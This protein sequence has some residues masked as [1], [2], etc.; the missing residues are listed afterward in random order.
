[1]GLTLILYASFGTGHERAAMAIQEAVKEYYPHEHV[2]M[3][4]VLSFSNKP[5][6]KIYSSVYF[7]II[8]KV[9][10][11]WGYLFDMSD[12]EFSRKEQKIHSLFNNISV[13]QLKKYLLKKKPDRV[14]CTHFLPLER[15]SALKQKGLMRSQLYCAITDYCVHALWI[16]KNVDAYFVGSNEAKR[17]L[18][19][20]G[21]N[22]DTIHV[23]GIPISLEFSKLTNVEKL[24]KRMKITHDLPVV[25]CMSGGFGLGPMEQILDSFAFH[26]VK[27]QIIIS[28][29]RNRVMADSIAKNRS[30]WPFPIFLLPYVTN[31][32]E[33]F[34]LADVVV[35]KPGGLSTTE[36]MAKEKPLIIINPIPGQE[37]RNSDFLLENGI[38]AKAQCPRDVAYKTMEILYNPSI[39]SRMKR[40]AKK[41]GRPNAAKDIA[42]IIYKHNAG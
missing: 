4:D 39:Y 32:H 31:L 41:F 11:L 17:E 42:D 27:A 37:E 7:S 23:K 13:Y 26:N 2:A 15:V 28:C 35:S 6:K 5:I 30:K 21:I 9:P 3:E 40:M 25:L 1:M 33:Y 20:A 18:I 36:I 29:G 34:D 24:R 8:T 14:I 22:P 12:K 19:Y 38:A 10:H 16:A